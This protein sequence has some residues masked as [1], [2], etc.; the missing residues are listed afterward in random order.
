MRKDE[1][2]ED[3]RPCRRGEEQLGGQA[4]DPAGRRR[5]GP[6]ASDGY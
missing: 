6:E 1:A 4:A 2:R 5:G 3:H